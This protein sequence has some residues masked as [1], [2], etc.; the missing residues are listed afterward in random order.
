MLL[1]KPLFCYQSEPAVGKLELVLLV[2]CPLRGTLGKLTHSFYESKLQ[3]ETKTEN[4]VV[5]LLALKRSQLCRVLFLT[6]EIK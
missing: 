3:L 1:D 5:F 6:T 2:M 4:I